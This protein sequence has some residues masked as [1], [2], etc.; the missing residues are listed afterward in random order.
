M[1]NL[2]CPV[3]INMQ[4]ICCVITSHYNLTATGRAALYS[5][6]SKNRQAM[7]ITGCGSVHRLPHP[8]LSL[9]AASEGT[10]A[11]HKT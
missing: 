2:V 7:N 10:A 1:N 3:M 4:A 11:C 9:V 6:T 5:M 8:M